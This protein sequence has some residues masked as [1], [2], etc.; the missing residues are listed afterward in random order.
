MKD[1]ELIRISLFACLMCLIIGC[2]KKYPDEKPVYPITGVITVDGVP[3]EGLQIKLH[4]EAGVDS[5]KPTFPSGFSTGDGKIAISTYA[6]G[7]G[8]PAGTY[9][10]TIELRELDLISMAYSGPDKLN[11][12]YADAE[13]P[14]I[15]WTISE[16]VVNDMGTIELTTK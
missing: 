10:V 12:R 7:D 1:F 6:N 5:A 4:D 2:E 16:S 11:E 15:Q 8:A 14:G 3:Q 13:K 9:K